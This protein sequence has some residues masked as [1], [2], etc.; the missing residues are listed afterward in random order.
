MTLSVQFDKQKFKEAVWFLVDYCPP[1]ELGNVKLHKM[2][3]FS[4]MLKFLDTGSPL[5]GVE[6]Q[7]QKFGPTA[8]HLSAAV[9]ELAKEGV[10]KLRTDDYHGFQK[11]TYLAVRGYH[12][13]ALSDA[14]IELLTD[15]ADFVRGKT[16]KEISELS[17]NAAWETAELGETIPY[18]TALMLAPVE[19]REDDREWARESALEHAHQGL[20]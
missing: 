2:L 6:Y 3:Y 1:D 19:V 16:A 11:K 12:R 14:D 5:T 18:F 20:V 8:R 15:V 13:A 9:S 17:H 4:D 7:K 10:I